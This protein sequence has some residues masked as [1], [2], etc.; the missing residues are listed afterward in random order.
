[1]S[2]TGRVVQTGALPPNN[3]AP[4]EAGSSNVYQSAAMKSTNQNQ[5]QNT[6]T[7]QGGRPRKRKMQMRGGANG[8]ANNA[9]PVVVVAGAPS[10]DTN[11]GG[12]NANNVAIAT[13]ANKTSSQAALD[14]TVGGTQAQAAAISANQQNEYYGTGG[15]HRRRTSYKKGGSFPVWGCF[16]GGKKSR[17]HKKSCKCKRRKTRKHYK[18]HHHH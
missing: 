3:V 18:K 13:L 11:K 2:I 8:V 9:A 1:M 15:S 16:S 6:L 14:G 7:K 5:L 12:T 4:L 17:R 10:F